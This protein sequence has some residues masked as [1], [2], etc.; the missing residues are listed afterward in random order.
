MDYGYNGINNGDDGIVTVMSFDEFA[1]IQDKMEQRRNIRREKDRKNRITYFHRQRIF[2]AI[3]GAIG[4]FFLILGSYIA[5]EIMQIFGAAVGL[6]GLFILTTKQMIVVD[7]YFLE[8]QD[9]MF[10]NR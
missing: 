6:V 2:G 4:I 9:R 5:S 1:N 8:C 10:N 3:V 7:S